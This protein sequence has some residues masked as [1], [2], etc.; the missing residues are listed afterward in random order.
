V[1]AYRTVVVGTDG[2]PS[3][4]RAVSRAAALAG[5]VG[6][7]LVVACAYEPAEEAR[8]VRR[9]QEVLGADAAGLDVASH[10]EDVLRGALTHAREAGATDVHPVPVTGPPAEALMDLADREQ[11]DLIVV[12]NRGLNT[13]KGRLLGSVPSDV[14]RRSRI[15]V[16][17]VHTTG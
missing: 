10:A 6:A 15:D 12:G 7:R 5:A 11:A 14:T 3:S 8:D 13:L 16:L 1:S 17:V 9:A 4:L 2:S